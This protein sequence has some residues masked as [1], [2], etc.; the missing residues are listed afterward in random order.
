MAS[1]SKCPKCGF[2]ITGTSGPICPMCGARLASPLR[3]NLWIVLLVQI[4]ASTA[5]MMVFRFPKIMIAIF[6]GMILI[7]T[8]LSSWAKTRPLPMT[9]PT[10]PVARPALFR[11]AS[12]GIAI[13]AL[14]IICFLLFGSVMFLNDWMRWHQYEGQPYHRTDFEV[15]EVHYQKGLKGSVDLSA[16]GSVEG[17]RERMNLRP[18]IQSQM[19]NERVSNEDELSLLVPPG[20][21][22]PVYFFPNLKGRAR[23]QLYTA[24]PTAEESHR[25]ALNTMQYALLGLAVSAGILFLLVRVRRSCFAES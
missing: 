12:V 23:V 16:S 6:V 1:I 10:K 25:A 22:I 4:V 2:D 13:C 3:A 11:T 7:G 8:A 9:G 17:N 5:F 15:A 20:T 19:H 18:Y 24:V 14:A 21:I